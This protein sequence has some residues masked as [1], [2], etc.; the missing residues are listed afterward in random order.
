MSSWFAVYIQE[1]QEICFVCTVHNVF[2]FLQCSV[3][4]SNA[5]SVF[6]SFLQTIRSVEMVGGTTKTGYQDMRT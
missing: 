5:S 2:L 3:C 1:V 6:V 4:T